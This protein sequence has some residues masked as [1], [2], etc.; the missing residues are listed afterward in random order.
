MIKITSIKTVGQEV[1]LQIEY[2]VGV[3]VKSMDLPL[4]EVLSRVG[5]LKKLLGGAP[6]VDDLKPVLVQIVNEKRRG[7]DV[8]APLDF[9]KYIGVDLE[10]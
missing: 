4:S 9:S 6:T 8:A 7:L 2:S 3:L 10:G 5:E 1:T